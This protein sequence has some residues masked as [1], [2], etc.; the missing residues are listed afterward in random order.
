MSC[1]GAQET[2]DNCSD[3]YL[4][5]ID[6]TRPEIVGR[7]SRAIVVFE[8]RRDKSALRLLRPGFRHCFCLVGA[9][10]RWT[11]C[12]PLKT[13]I[14]IVPLV[15]PSEEEIARHYRA[16]GRTVLMGAV[17]AAAARFS[18]RPWPATCVEIV[19]RVLNLDAPGV[20]TPAQLHRALLDPA[21]PGGGFVPCP[22]EGVPAMTAVDVANL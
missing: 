22:I 8:D 3:P 18:Y 9:G 16:T 11:I 7:G 2:M 4:D 17:A 6:S 19:K 10:Q 20:L 21:R 5:R 15:G 14:E 12:D 1:Q 13:R